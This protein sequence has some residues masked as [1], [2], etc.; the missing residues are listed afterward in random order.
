MIEK[1]ISS[2]EYTAAILNDKVLP[3][4]KIIPSNEFY[5]FDAK[6]NQKDT[7][8]KKAALEEKREIFLKKIVKNVNQ[9]RRVH[10]FSKN[11]PHFPLHCRVSTQSPHTRVCKH[12][13]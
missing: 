9:M 3:I 8:Y 1:K 2:D 12:Q 13:P 6:Y 4:I 5:D 7:I 11:F 10:P